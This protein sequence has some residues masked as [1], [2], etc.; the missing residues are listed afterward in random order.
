MTAAQKQYYLAHSIDLSQP[1]YYPVYI[2]ELNHHSFSTAKRQGKGEAPTDNSILQ[3]DTRLNQSFTD[4]HEHY[5]PRESPLQKDTRKIQNRF[6]SPQQ[7]K[8]A[9]LDQQRSI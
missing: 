3:I 4:H 6:I 1:D 5:Y 2:K 8:D 9:I 7:M